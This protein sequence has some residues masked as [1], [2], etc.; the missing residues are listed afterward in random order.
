MR[1]ML[2]LLAGGFLMGACNPNYLETTAEVDMYISQ[3]RH[4]AVCV[5]Y[6][7][8]EDDALREYTAE[9]LATYP[10]VQAATDCTC[11]AIMAYPHGAYDVALVQGLKGSAREDLTD[12]V[13][14]AL[15]GTPVIEERVRLV[16]Q[17]AAIRSVNGYAKVAQLA[18]ADSEAPEVRVSALL[19]LMPVRDKNTE[20]VLGRLKT[21]VD[22]T[23]RATAAEMF[24]NVTDQPIVDALVTA[25]TDDVDGLVRA[26]AL[27]AVVK[28]KLEQTDAMVCSMM[29]DDPD[30]RVR[31]RAVRSFKGSKRDVALK[32]LQ[33]RLLTEEKD[34]RV[35]G[36]TLKA[37]YASPSDKAP[38]I[39]CDAIGPFV[40]MYVK[41][42]PV[43]KMS[44]ADIVKHQ[45]N[46]DFENSYEC[47]ATA[48][49][50]GGY[51]CWG[52]WYLADWFEQLGGKA[53]R[54]T[55]KGMDA[56]GEIIF[57]E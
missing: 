19:G 10:E 31:D 22:P 53:F 45:N 50:Q 43:H 55:C 46:R 3:A 39:L 4:S 23:V 8:S 38:K 42:L 26:A 15:D 7:S 1:S 9:R 41:E 18:V 12:C 49:R 6:K 30:P 11:E 56:P 51:T 33:K 13:L 5:A 29:M 36:S 44:G 21:D 32:C 34:D 47:V 28:L 40:R 2:A 54:P 37:I 57:G 16:S 48:R 25:A 24:E 17:I 20:L 14:P 52:K 27:K 35:R